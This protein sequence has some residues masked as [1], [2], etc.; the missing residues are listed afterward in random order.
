M[1]LVADGGRLQSCG[2]SRTARESLSLRQ[3]DAGKLFSGA[4]RARLHWPADNELLATGAQERLQFARCCS[5]LTADA[6]GSC[7]TS[8]KARESLSLRQ[9]DAGKLFSGAW[10]ERLHWP[11]DN[12]LLTMSCLRLWIACLRATARRVTRDERP[13]CVDVH[14]TEQPCPRGVWHHE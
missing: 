3:G 7:S 12:E 5:S 4:W 9:G 10:R 13:E 1:L 2:T 11:A 8:R 6:C 14:E